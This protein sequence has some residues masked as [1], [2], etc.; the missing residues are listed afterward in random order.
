MN[1]HL[2]LAAIIGLCLG[3]WAATGFAQTPGGGFA[4]QQ[5]EPPALSGSTELDALRLRMEQ[6]ERELQDLRNQLHR[7]QGESSLPA[8]PYPTTHELPLPADDAPP[9]HDERVRV[10]EVEIQTKPTY[11]IRGRLFFDHV[12]FDDPSALGV[13]R[14]TETGFDTARIGVEGKVYENVEY[15]I[16]LEFE[17]TE[18]DFKTVYC[19]INELPWLGSFRAGHFY[20]PLAGLDEDSGS[21]YQMFMERSLAVTAFIP[22]RSFGYMVQ[23]TALDEDIYWAVGM[24]R[25][26]SD[27]SPPARG[28]ITGDTGDWVADGRIAWNP[29]YDEPSGGRYLVHVGMGYSFRTDS[30]LV[31]FE[32]VSELGNQRGFL[33]TTVPGDRNYSL[34]VPEF[35]V[36]WGPWSVQSEWMFVPTGPA[37]FWGGYVEASYFL[38][39]DHRGYRRSDKTLTRPVIVEDFFSVRTLSGLVCGTGGWE[40]KTRWSHVD[41]EDGAGPLRGVQDNWS[42]GVNWYLNS[43]A[44]MMFEYVYEDV[45][46]VNGMSGVANNFGTRFHVQW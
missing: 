7:S 23:N 33:A 24:F 3:S 11:H 2:R 15:Q 46:L 36:I 6:Y 18:V 32:T 28:T 14:E 35:L 30:T 43:Y 21:N 39:G 34:F 13:D 41:L 4:P 1:R 22:S 17:G 40:L 20:E 44:R 8:A 42:V 45:R 10:E 27:D 19:Q 26:E 12:T 31:E 25:H 5:N 37:S 9:P 16:E 29:Y 38:T